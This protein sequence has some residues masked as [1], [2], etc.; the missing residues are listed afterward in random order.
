MNDLGETK[1][2]FC[3]RR[4]GKNW[5]PYRSDLH[6]ISVVV[7]LIGSGRAVLDIGCGD[8]TIGELMAKNGNTVCGVDISA[9][10]VS[11]ASGRGIKASVCDIES[12]NLP[13]PDSFFDIVVATEII[14]HIF[15]T[16]SFL[17]KIK[18]VLKPHGQLIL[19]TPN[20]ASFGRRLFLLLGRNPLIEVA[21]RPESAGHIRYFVKRALLDLLGE[22]GF[23]VDY[24]G[25]DV[26]IFDVH[27]K[28]YSSFLAKLLPTLGS[29]LIVR[30]KKV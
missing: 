19:T 9:R 23:S 25:S 22:N 14:E 12:E 16:D 8:G 11:L 10:A 20:L 4:Y 24:F 18:A 15:D 28:V 1:R 21:A 27:G 30:A 29:R 7:S 2:N 3:D 6:R 17:D 13:F 5:Q 26:I